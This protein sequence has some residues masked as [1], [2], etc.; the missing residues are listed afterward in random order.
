[1]ANDSQA[2][3]KPKV[4]IDGTAL[5]TDLAQLLELAVVDEHLHQP[6]MFMLSFRDIG[7]DIAKQ[8]NVQI[9][10]AHGAR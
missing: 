6:D 3:V 9:G 4:E 2:G 10:S 8:V 7:R 1:M 5:S